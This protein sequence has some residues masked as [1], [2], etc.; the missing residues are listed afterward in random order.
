M[1]LGGI[2]VVDTATNIG[3]IE[4]IIVLSG[5]VVAVVG[6]LKEETGS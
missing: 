1:I 6:F 4:Y 2:L 5:L 3:G